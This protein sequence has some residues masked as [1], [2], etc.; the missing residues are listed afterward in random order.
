VLAPGLEL[1]DPHEWGQEQSRRRGS[2]LPQ[3]QGGVYLDGRS[4]SLQ[5]S[6][7][8]WDGTH[9][10]PPWWMLHYCPQGV[11]GRDGG[12]GPSPLSCADRAEGLPAGARCER[13]RVEDCTSR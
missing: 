5:M 10:T 8:V 7:N 1:V 6:C 9:P 2:L 4:G 12:Y 13:W 3:V 11:L